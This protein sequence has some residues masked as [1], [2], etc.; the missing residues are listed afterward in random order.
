MMSLAVLSVPWV[1]WSGVYW[2][3]ILVQDLV[4]FAYSLHEQIVRGL[5]IIKT[6]LVYLH[7]RLFINLCYASWNI[8]HQL[9]PTKR[10]QFCAAIF[11]I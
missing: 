5:K 4:Q 3:R 1:G 11:D 7:I 8:G 6:E 9:V 10:A 2:A